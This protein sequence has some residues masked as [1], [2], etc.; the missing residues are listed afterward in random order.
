MDLISATTTVAITSGDVHE[1]FYLLKVLGNGAEV[2]SKTTKD[3]YG[4]KYNVGVDVLRGHFYVKETVGQHVYQLIT[5]KVAIVYAATARFI[6]S[7]LDS[8]Q[9]AQGKELFIPFRAPTFG[10]SGCLKWILTSFPLPRDFVS[11]RL[12]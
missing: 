6:C 1:D 8:I 11:H 10:H 3:N 7:D 12:P 5:N 4:A 9:T 2:L